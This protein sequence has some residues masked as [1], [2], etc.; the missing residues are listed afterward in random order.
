MQKQNYY[1]STINKVCNLPNI[2]TAEKVVFIMRNAIKNELTLT[3]LG[4]QQ[5]KNFGLDL[6]SLSDVFGSNISYYIDSNLCN[7]QTVEFISQ[8]YNKIQPSVMDISTIFNMTIESEILLSA[9]IS[10]VNSGISVVSTDKNNVLQN[11]VSY[12]TDN[13]ITFNEDKNL[14]YLSGICCIINNSDVICIP[15]TAMISGFISNI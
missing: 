8:G 9:I 1:F 6:K 3:G 13:L 2:K 15:V 4:K 11:L 10:S 5:A 7:K 14:N 12:C